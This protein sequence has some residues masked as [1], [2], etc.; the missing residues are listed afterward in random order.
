[1]TYRLAIDVGS[2]RT[3]WATTSRNDAE[4][5]TIDG[6][7]VESVVALLD[8]QLVAG[9][10][11][12]KAD[13]AAVQHVTRQFVQRLGESTP[14]MIG[15]TPYGA[16]SLVGRLLTSVI[17][18]V[19]ARRGGEPGAVVIV[20]DTGLDDY[21]KGLLT[22]AARVAG[23]PMANLVLVSRDEA[24][25]AEV[26][27]GLII[28]TGYA[29][30][31]GASLIGWVLRP[32]IATV[33]PAATA[34]ATGG[35]GA[36]VGVA[37]GVAATV[38]GGAVLGAT[39]MGHAAAEAAS[40][41]AAAGP[42]GAPLVAGPTGAPISA[43]PTGSPLSTPPTA[44]PAGSPLST[45]PTA[46]P[47]GTPINT[48][49]TAGPT[50][51]P[52]NTPPTA[53]PTGTP[54][55]TPPTAGPTGTPISTAPPVGPLGTQI[56]KKA[57]RRVPVVVAAAVAIVAVVAVV[58]VVATNNDSPATLTNSSLDTSASGSAGS[59]PT[60]SA[61]LGLGQTGKVCVHGIWKMSNE[62]FKNMIGAAAALGAIGTFDVTGS[63][64]IEIAPDGVWTMTYDKW[65]MSAKMA[66]LS[67]DVT[68]TMNGVDVSRGEFLDDGSF[69]FHDVSVGTQLTF[70]ANVNGAPLP[71][72]VAPPTR[73]AVSG[74]GTYTCEGDV[75]TLTTPDAPSPFVMDRVG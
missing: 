28:P 2:E 15:A 21:R 55:N 60:G 19:T 74:A 69:N 8:G 53:G 27:N 34:A 58:V 30:V 39:V 63:T 54:I 61:A 72:P 66:D 36:T 65:T 38:A 3:M 13:P 4:Q 23:L 11:V 49:P 9:A 46:G 33:L 25:S 31:A 44:G 47:T 26:P 57:P 71:I 16:E 5:T 20:H 67:A 40:T 68:V 18:E 62:N 52:I 29:V 45:P 14:M 48:P 37:A 24:D 12:T 7:T 59:G 22:E 41:V 17:T 43:G 42:A 1:M 70:N 75:L 6:A 10:E 56:I 64:K 51:T 32:D 50:G 35:A 73:T